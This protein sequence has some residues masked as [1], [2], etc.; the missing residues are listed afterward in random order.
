M[1]VLYIL[2]F[3]GAKNKMEKKQIELLKT[4]IEE[5][6]AGYDFN[7]FIF[8]YIDEEELVGVTDISELIEYLREL[9]DDLQIT[10]KEVIYHA[11]AIEYLAENDPSLQESLSI[12]RDFGYTIDNIHSEL[13]ATLLLSEENLK[14]YDNFLN[15][16]ENRED[17]IFDET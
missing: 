14:D 1:E 12:A 4:I 6:E 16:I 3:K 2:S 7:D 9:N 5:E 11:N 17:E 13:L 10:E 15:D 8:N